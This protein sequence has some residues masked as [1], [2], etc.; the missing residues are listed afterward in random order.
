MLL[1]RTIS[2]LD[3]G[4]IPADEARQLGHYGYLQ[5]LAGLPGGVAYRAAALGALDRARPFAGNSPAIAEFCTLLT[6]SVERPLA[7]LP[8]EVPSAR[9]R[10]GAKVRRLR[11]LSQ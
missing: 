4:T 5:W 6:A 1:D 7:A 10:G 3:I 8:L 11:R 2:Q 9:R